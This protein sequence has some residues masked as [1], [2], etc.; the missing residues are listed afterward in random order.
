MSHCVPEAGADGADAFAVLH[1]RAV[2]LGFAGTSILAGWS[3]SIPAGLTLVLGD[4]GAGKSSVLRLLAGELAADA[5]ELCLH[6]HAHASAGYRQ[7]V[8]WRDPGAAWPHGL[9]PATWSAQLAACHPQWQPGEWLRHVQGFGLQPH[10]D[11]AMFQLSTG[12][13]RKV[14]LAGALASGAP[15]TLIDEPVAALDRASIAYL[16]AELL[17]QACSP[18]QPGRAVVVAHYDTLDERLPWRCTLELQP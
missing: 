11:K 10:L 15:L 1:A 4:E 16:C 14:L 12:S 5:G 6:G 18:P 8:F 7:Q 3:G 9:T 2:E 13:R 17:R